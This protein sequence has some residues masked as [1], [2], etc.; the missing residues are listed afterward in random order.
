VYKIGGAAV[1]DPLIVHRFGKVEAAPSPA[2]STML[3]RVRPGRI[4]GSLQRAAQKIVGSGGVV[5]VSF[6]VGWA[7]HGASS[8]ASCPLL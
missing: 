1:V 4:T 6:D 3:L 2:Y 8:T 5:V 7:A